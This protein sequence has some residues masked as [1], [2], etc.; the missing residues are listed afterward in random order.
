MMPRPTAG[1][2]TEPAL[3]LARHREVEADAAALGE[4]R[5]VDDRADRAVDAVREHTL[6]VG[7]RIARILEKGIP[8]TIALDMANTVTPEAESFNIVAEIPGT[9]PAL[10]DGPS[11]PAPNDHGKLVS[12]VEK[13]DAV[14]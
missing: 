8:V 11:E 14:G 5:G 4:R 1:H 6:E 13:S 9:D 12:Q 7:E 2:N 3:V 10:K